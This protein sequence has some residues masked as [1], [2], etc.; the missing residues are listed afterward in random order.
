MLVFL[1][2]WY[3]W[4]NLPPSGNVGRFV[5]HFG[6]TAYHWFETLT[7]PTGGNHPAVIC[8]FVLSGFC[9]HYPFARRA[10]RGE[11]PDWRGYFRRRFL[12]IMPV[13]WIATLWGLV[14][15]AAEAWRPTGDEFLQSNSFAEPLG[16]VMRLLGLEGIYPREIIAGNC[17]LT[18]V[19][20]EMVMY[21]LYP[22]IYWC[23]VRGAWTALAGGFLGLQVLGMLLLPIVSPFWVFNSVLILG[24]FWY[25]GA[26]AAQLFANG[27]ASLRPIWLIAAW[28][29]FLLLKGMTHFYGLNL[30]KQ[31]AWGLVCTCA[32][33]TVLHTQE[34]Q[35]KRPSHPVIR[36]LR[37]LSDIS[38][39]LYALHTPAIMLTSWLIISF[40]P[41]GGYFSQLALSLGLTVLTVLVVHYGIER[42]FYP[43]LAPAPER[44]KPVS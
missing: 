41:G 22:L 23:A 34:K 33:L 10:Q 1:T 31:A 18:T 11:P 28:G 5:Q 38:Y 29:G 44:K 19:T 43:K 26:L 12:R 9:I 42:R 8:F 40:V 13:F 15:V 21:A 30:I 14:F 7:W 3:V 32:I 25:A 4:A 36:A 17:I 37:Y 6:S 2:H 39:S 27:R 20:A 16:V 35:A 24:L